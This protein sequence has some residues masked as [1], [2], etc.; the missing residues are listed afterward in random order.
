MT[1]QEK[2]EKYDVEHPELYDLF[3]RFAWEAINAGRKILSAN[4]I[5]ERIRWETEVI[6]KGDP[7][8]INNNYRPY[9]ARKWMEENKR[10]GMFRTRRLFSI[11][12]TRAGW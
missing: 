8:K 7:F 3:D 12:G 4:L 11:K 6:T 2:F 5:F 10:P 9:Y 1:L